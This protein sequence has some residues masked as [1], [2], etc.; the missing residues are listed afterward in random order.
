MLST[1]QYDA[2]L[3]MEGSN[4][5]GTRDAA[6]YPAVI[7]A[8]QDMLHD[9]KGRGIR[10]YLATIP[11]MNPAGFR[12]V[13]WSQV[14]GFND[15]IRGLAASEGVTLVDVYQALNADINTYIGFDGLHPNA[16]GYAKIADLFATAIR[17][18]LE[19]P[20]TMTVASTTGGWRARTSSSAT[21]TATDQ[22]S[23]AAA[24]RRR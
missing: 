1:G 22:D 18:T 10:P 24:P 2:V 21:P 19:L 7:A 8:L 16:S 6:I 15:L 14:P 23:A 17:Q 11:P 12:A 9:A 5:L 20:S 13:A 4:D 3:L